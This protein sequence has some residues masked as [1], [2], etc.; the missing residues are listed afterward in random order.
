MPITP[1]PDIT[2][3]LMS[4]TTESTSADANIEVLTIE[5]VNVVV[6]NV[7]QSGF[8]GTV[9]LNTAN[10]YDVDVV[11]V[12]D[13]W[14]NL[15]VLNWSIQFDNGIQVVSQGTITRA[16]IENLGDGWELDFEGNNLKLPDGRLKRDPTIG[17]EALIRLQVHRGEWW[18]DL[19]L[20]STLHL[21]ND[22]KNAKKEADDA[23]RLAL[24]PMID[25][26]ALAEIRTSDVLV[27]EP[28]GALYIR[29]ELFPVAGDNSID[30]GR[31]PLGG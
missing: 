11:A 9:A 30:L 25:R 12:T 31:L 20:G 4:W 22:T 5:G 26:G 7:L 6:N 24:K 1:N 14:G 21:I 27:Q 2:S 8:L 29:V 15:P 17:T 23:I 28:E 19:E 16:K 10:G 18:G 3:R 13:P